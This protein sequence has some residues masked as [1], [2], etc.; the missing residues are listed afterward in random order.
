LKRGEK[1]KGPKD[2][3]GAKKPGEREKNKPVG[4][5][6]WGQKREKKTRPKQSKEGGGNQAAAR[7]NEK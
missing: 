1:N 3:T 6:T 2:P 5:G 4:V 7:F